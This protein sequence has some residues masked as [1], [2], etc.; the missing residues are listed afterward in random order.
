[1]KKIL[2]SFCLFLAASVAQSYA[3]GSTTASQAPSIT[4][5]DIRGG[6]INGTKRF[7]V[8]VSTN[9]GGQ[10]E[11]MGTGVISSNN[12]AS[13]T[14][15]TGENVTLSITPNEGYELKTLFVDGV[16]VLDKIAD[17]LYT[18][19][20]ISKNISVSATFEEKNGIF[21]DLDG[22]GSVTS[23]DAILIYNY[24]ADNSAVSIPAESLDL[25]GSGDITSADVIVIYNLIANS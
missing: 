5:D 13:A 7:T 19:E 1:M 6:D 15:N 17:G 9:E 24:I 11:I 18:I 25:D 4:A 16:D 22:D 8:Q 20:A 14:I 21:G 3:A 12:V 23:A 10:I 2:L